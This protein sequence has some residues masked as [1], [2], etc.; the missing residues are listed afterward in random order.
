LGSKWLETQPESAKSKSS[1][2]NMPILTDLQ[3]KT[4]TEPVL[5]EAYE[6][7]AH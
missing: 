5:E 2:N 1:G 7:S 4:D 3:L 6:K